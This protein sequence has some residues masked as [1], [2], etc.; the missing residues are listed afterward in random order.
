MSTP[1]SLCIFVADG[2]PDGLCIVDKSNR[3]GKAL[4]FPRELLPHL[5]CVEGSP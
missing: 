1:F 3:I 4:V 2:D 5:D